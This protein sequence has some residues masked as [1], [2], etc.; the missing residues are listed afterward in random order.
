MPPTAF[1]DC[2]TAYGATDAELEAYGTVWPLDVRT[3]WRFLVAQAAIAGLG[4][5]AAIWFAEYGWRLLLVVVALAALVSATVSGLRLRVTARQ[6]TPR[7]AQLTLRSGW[8]R[9]VA[10]PWEQV[11]EIALVDRGSGRLAALRLR[12]PLGD[13]GPVGRWLAGIARRLDAGYD[14]LLAPSDGDAELLSRILLRYCIDRRA[15]RQYLAA[16]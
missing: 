3:G 7:A 4:A 15:R 1:P 5:V 11:A 10:V 13:S 12:P 2:W 8:G 16:D 14:W 9:T 6:A